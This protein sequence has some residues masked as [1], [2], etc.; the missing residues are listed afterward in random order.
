MN[1]ILIPAYKPD[2]KL[3]ELC[4]KLLSHPNV[5]VVVVDDGSGE[6]YKHIFENLDPRVVRLGYGE[7]HGK[8]Y[9]LKTGIRYIY[10]NMPECERLV[11]ADADGQHR[12]EDIEKVIAKS[13][14]CPG[15]L[16][17]GGRRFD[18]SNVPFRSRFGNACTRLVFRLASGVSVYDTQTGLRGFDRAGMKLFMDVKGD[19]Y[20]YEMNML[21]KASEEDIP[22]KEI[23]IATVYLEENKSSHFNPLKDSLRIYKSIIKFAASSFIAFLIDYLVFLLLHRVFRALGW[24]MPGLDIGKLHLGP[25]E[26]ANAIARVVSSC[27][28]FFVNHRVVFNSKEKI[29]KAALKYAM[30]ALFIFCLDTFVLKF[31]MEV[32]SIPDWLAKPMTETIMFFVNFPIQR[33]FVFKRQRRS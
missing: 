20:E 7:N 18:E 26:A 14:E 22:I 5:Q 32:C 12:Y 13:Q 27:V 8:G 15:A 6:S 10:E 17:L 28:N 9:A 3:I 2:E 4:E 30:L 21:L 29:W 16:V 33:K 25:K 23:T 24:F 11:T 19:R 31:F 1:A